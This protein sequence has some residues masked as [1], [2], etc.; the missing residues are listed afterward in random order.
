MIKADS[1]GA[2]QRMYIWICDCVKETIK[3]T[4]NEVPYYIPLEGKDS[5]R[6]LFFCQKRS[7]SFHGINSGKKSHL[8]VYS[9]FFIPNS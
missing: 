7:V 3:Q 5:L 1:T 8:W 2:A 9:L 4:L 6:L